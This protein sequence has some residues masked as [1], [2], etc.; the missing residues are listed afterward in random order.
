MLV[1]HAVPEPWLR[2][3]GT[4]G[5]K[6][7][8]FINPPDLYL[9]TF[10]QAVDESW[11][12]F[13]FGLNDNSYRSALFF[14]LHGLYVARQRI[15]F[16][17]G[18]I[19]SGNVMIQQELSMRRTPTPTTL[20]YGEYEATV[21]S[22]FVPRFIDYGRSI[23]A[24]HHTGD[25][26]PYSNDLRALRNMFDRHFDDEDREDDIDEAIEFNKFVASS[27]WRDLETR[28]KQEGESL[29]LPLLEHDYFDVPEIQRQRVKRQATEPIERCF[30]CCVPQPT[31]QINH[32]ASPPKY[33]CGQ[34]CHESMK[35]ISAF[36]K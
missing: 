34:W 29:I 5:K 15:G 22:R 25:D 17:H 1:Y 26:S 35:G 9:F 31:H 27:G 10:V 14:L 23:T 8:L 20:R 36:I 18:D 16:Q 21:T 7:E 4:R 13:S 19:H 28:Y 6:H 33:F 2:A 32:R 30:H 12:T 3:I 24:K 11:D